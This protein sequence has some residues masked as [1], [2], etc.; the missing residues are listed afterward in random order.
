MSI[1]DNLSAIFNQYIGRDVALTVTPDLHESS[2]IVQVDETA[3]LAREMHALAKEQG[4][5]LRWL[6]ATVVIP[7]NSNSV[8]VHVTCADNLKTARIM[9]IGNN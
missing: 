4:L 9:S 3:D 8:T 2:L 5:S 7:G 6:P 1:H